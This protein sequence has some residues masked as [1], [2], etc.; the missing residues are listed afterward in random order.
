MGRTVRSCADARKRETRQEENVQQ[1]QSGEEKSKLTSCGP[2]VSGTCHDQQS[3]HLDSQD[4]SFQNGRYW[5]HKILFI[6]IKI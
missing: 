4:P 1:A 2:P 5:F 6:K 3:Y